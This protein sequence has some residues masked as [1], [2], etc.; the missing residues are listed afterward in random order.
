M[1]EHYLRALEGME[2]VTLGVGRSSGALRSLAGLSTPLVA[3]VLVV[4]LV[5]T[6]GLGVGW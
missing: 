2:S 5:L 4:V 6:A 3:M 1:E